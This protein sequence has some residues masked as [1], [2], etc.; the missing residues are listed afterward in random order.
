MTHEP[1]NPKIALWSLCTLRMLVLLVAVIFDTKYSC[2]ALGAHLILE[3]LSSTK[4]P[5]K[6]PKFSLLR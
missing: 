4:T 3:I 6:I 2:V 1:V 5:L